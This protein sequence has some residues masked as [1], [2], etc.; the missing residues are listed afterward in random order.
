MS[1]TELEILRILSTSG[2]DPREA[3]QEVVKAVQNLSTWLDKAMVVFSDLKVAQTR[4]GTILATSNIEQHGSVEYEF[5]PSCGCCPDPSL[6]MSK[7]VYFEGRRIYDK[8][9]FEITIGETHWTDKDRTYF[10]LWEAVDLSKW[11]NKDREVVEEYL[12]KSK[13]EAEEDNNDDD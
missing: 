7:L 5:K 8:S 10:A 6:L 12:A 2:Q 4:G 1:K 11:K 3:V 9:Y 13:Q